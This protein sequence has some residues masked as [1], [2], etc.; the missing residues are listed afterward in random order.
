MFKYTRF[1]TNTH[2][3]RCRWP[4]GAGVES[5][6]EVWDATGLAHSRQASFPS[7]KTQSS[8]QNKKLVPSSGPNHSLT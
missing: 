3:Y 5:W 8:F 7:A 2:I 6:C 4:G 1:N